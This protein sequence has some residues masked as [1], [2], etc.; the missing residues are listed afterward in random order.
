MKDFEQKKARI[1]TRITVKVTTASTHWVTEI[2]GGIK[3]AED[4][5]LNNYFDTGAYPIERMEK[6]FKVEQLTGA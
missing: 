4:Y 6:P 3:A 1:K 2:N 5:F